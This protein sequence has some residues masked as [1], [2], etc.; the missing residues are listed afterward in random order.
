M[1]KVTLTALA[2][3]LLAV[4]SAYAQ[5]TGA[6][7]ATNTAACKLPGLAHLAGDTKLTPGCVYATSLRITKPLTLDCQ[8][9]TLDGG[10]TLMNGIVIDSMGTPLSGVV[11][12]NC[13]IKNYKSTGMTITW[14][15]SDAEKLA[16]TNN[17]REAIYARAPQ[18]ILVEN[19]LVDRAGSVGIYVDDYV[20]NVTLSKV[21][22][23]HSYGVGIYFEG[24]TRKNTVTQS[25]ILENGWKWQ[26][27][28]AWQPGIALDSSAYNLIT[29]TRFYRNGKMG[30]GLYRNCWENAAVDVN[31]RARWQGASNNIIG[32]NLFLDER[33]GVWV[34]SRMSSNLVGMKCGMTPYHRGP[35]G[36]TY[37]LDDAK[38]NQIRKN[39]FKRIWDGAVIVEDNNNRVEANTVESMLRGAPIVVGSPLR[40]K[41]LGQPVSGTVIG[42][43]NTLNGKP[44]GAVVTD[45]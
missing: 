29:N 11:I 43:E 3:L 38:S 41:V 35:A 40:A 21:T 6:A 12:R 33:I 15:V 18:N 7:V 5:S 30:V 27:R 39:T 34:G 10:G 20:S 8:G 17:N 1:H 23:Q 16:Q 13:Q 26:E 2:T 9:A 37:V 22:V 31:S 28:Q 4:P 42:N 32:G 45:R 24:S 36:E 44:V 25:A 14:S 19:V